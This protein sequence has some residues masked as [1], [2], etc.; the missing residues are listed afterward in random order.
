MVDVDEESE[1]NNDVLEAL[2]Q[3]LNGEIE[4]MI[5]AGATVDLDSLEVS[6]D[7]DG[8]YNVSIEYSMPDEEV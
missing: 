7:A 5:D 6:E 4:K 8:N 1:F 2:M 3:A